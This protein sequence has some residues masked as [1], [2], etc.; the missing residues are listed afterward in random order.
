[1]SRFVGYLNWRAD[2]G[3]EAV[4]CSDAQAEYDAEL[5]E[6]R[7]KPGQ[8]VMRVPG[9]TG[10]ITRGGSLCRARPTFSRNA[11]SRTSIRLIEKTIVPSTTVAVSTL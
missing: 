6:Q 10:D 9:K 3:Q 7:Q 5:V 8:D 4:V 11:E 1:M 2:D